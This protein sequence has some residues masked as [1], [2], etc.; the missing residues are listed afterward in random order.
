[1]SVGCYKK[2]NKKEKGLTVG[3]EKKGEGEASFGLLSLFGLVSSF[4]LLFGCNKFFPQLFFFFKYRTWEWEGLPPSFLVARFGTN[5]H[6]GKPNRS[7]THTLH[8]NNKRVVC[9]PFCVC[10]R[11]R[12]WRNGAWPKFLF[13]YCRFKLPLTWAGRESFFFQTLRYLATQFSKIGHHF[14]WFNA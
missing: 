12:R 9:S 1:M 8:T 11:R 4:L 5:T 14:T 10:V 13:C 3:R 7:Q 2:I 6:T